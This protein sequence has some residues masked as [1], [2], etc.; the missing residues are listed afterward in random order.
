[1]YLIIAC[2]VD[3]DLIVLE[4]SILEDNELKVAQYG[5]YHIV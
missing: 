1:M 5:E 4:A 2:K 3:I